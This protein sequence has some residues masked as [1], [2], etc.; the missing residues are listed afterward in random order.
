MHFRPTDNRNKRALWACT[1]SESALC[2]GGKSFY[3]SLLPLSLPTEHFWNSSIIYPQ[4]K[5][6]TG[7]ETSSFLYLHRKI[8]NTN[9][10]QD[11]KLVN[12]QWQVVKADGFEKICGSPGSTILE[13]PQG[14]GRRSGSS[15]YSRK[16]AADLTS[17]HKG[18]KEQA[19][20]T[21]GMKISFPNCLCLSA[22]AQLNARSL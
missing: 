17:C 1:T 11:H 15:P 20:L 3:F 16:A 10:Q 2:Q 4:L 19:K 5:H 21:H 14:T 7:E 22:E 9:A 13:A 6:E 8:F 18:R 12:K